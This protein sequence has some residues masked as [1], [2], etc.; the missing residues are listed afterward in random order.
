MDNENSGFDEADLAFMKTLMPEDA[1]PIGMFCVIQFFDS[2]GEMKW[3]RYH[4]FEAPVSQAAGVAFMG[5]LGM[6]GAS[7][8][9]IEWLGEE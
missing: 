3:K 7:N 4:P 2:N 8:T 5:I 1:I 6:L 9:G